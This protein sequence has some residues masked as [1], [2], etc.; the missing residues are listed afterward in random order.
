MLLESLFS[1]EMINILSIMGNNRY[2]K[3]PSLIKSRH[4]KALWM[5]Q[6]CITIITI[7]H[8]ALYYL[9]STLR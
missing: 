6:G 2:V 1:L 5:S 3:T 7:F 9:Q 4:L 8:A